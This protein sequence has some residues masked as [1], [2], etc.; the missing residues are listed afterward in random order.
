MG[1]G[2][3][4]TFQYMRLVTTDIIFLLALHK[5]TFSYSD[6]IYIKEGIASTPAS[7]MLVQHA[8]SLSE[9]EEGCPPSVV[10]ES[11]KSLS[12]FNEEYEDNCTQH[13]IHLHHN[14]TV[15]QP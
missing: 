6:S 3:C 15:G 1:S 14:Q 7:H 8:M 13:W 2:I 10:T 9:P 5:V 12:S 4:F 11:T